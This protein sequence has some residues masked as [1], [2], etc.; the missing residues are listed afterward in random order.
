MFLLTSSVDPGAL[1]LT[2]T[3]PVTRPGIWLPDGINDKLI[4]DVFMA[5]SSTNWGPWR[6]IYECCRY[7]PPPE[8]AAPE[9]TTEAGCKT[10]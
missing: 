4:Q 6:M 10:E 3:P 9:A 1:P 8:S 7:P 2:R 5:A